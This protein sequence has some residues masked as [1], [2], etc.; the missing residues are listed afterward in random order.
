MHV[1][2]RRTALVGA[3]PFP[4]VRF[5]AEELTFNYELTRAGGVFYFDPSIVV[6]HLNR[7]TLRAFFRAPA[8]ARHRLGD[9]AAAGPTPRRGCR[10]APSVISVLA[11][12][13]FRARARTRRAPPPHRAAKLILLSPLMLVGYVVWARLLA[14]GT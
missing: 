2:F 6:A 3:A 9:G 13:A 12:P 4:E 10:P 11:P 1:C 7:T 8:G 14:G 5:G